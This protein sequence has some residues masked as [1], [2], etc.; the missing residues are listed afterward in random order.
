MGGQVFWTI[1]RIQ[2]HCSGKLKYLTEF[3]VG[4]EGYDP[5]HYSWEPEANILDPHIVEDY[6]DYA[7][8]REQYTNQ[9]AKQTVS[10]GAILL[11]FCQHSN[12]PL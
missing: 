11:H 3:L 4:W 9:Q 8:S 7:A 1:G 6:W 10:L 12:K 5:S 2:N